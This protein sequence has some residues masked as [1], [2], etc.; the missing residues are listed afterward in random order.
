MGLLGIIFASSLNTVILCCVIQFTNWQIIGF[1][2]GLI[3]FLSFPVLVVLFCCNFAAI[4]CP[5]SYTALLME[6]REKIVRDRWH[7]GLEDFN[8]ECAKAK[9]Y[10]GK[11][12]V[13]YICYNPC[14]VNIE[15][16]KEGK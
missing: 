12:L 8:K 15:P 4:V 9:C 2:A 14:Y 11:W 3:L 13:A 16:I 6:E 7:R 10:R 1:A 5:D